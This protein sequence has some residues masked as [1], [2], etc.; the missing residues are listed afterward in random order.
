MHVYIRYG[1]CE[2]DLGEMPVLPISE[3]RVCVD[4]P[5]ELVQN[6]GYTDNTRDQLTIG[7]RYFERRPIVI[8]PGDHDLDPILKPRPVLTDR[9]EWVCVLVPQEDR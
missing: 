4:V 5:E 9:F 2:I 7:R 8:Y 6:R 1:K 3:D